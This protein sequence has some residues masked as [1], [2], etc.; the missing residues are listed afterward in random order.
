MTK[1][2]NTQEINWKQIIITAIIT[3]LMSLA[4]AIIVF[5]F[6]TEKTELI[7][8]EFPI[9][10]FQSNETELSILNY[11][12]KNIGQ[13]KANNVKI[14]IKLPESS[15]IKEPNI[16]LNNSLA[17]YKILKQEKNLIIYEIN[18]LYQYDNLNLSLLVENL[19]VRQ[20]IKIEIR[21]EDS[22]GTLNNNNDNSISPIVIYTTL[23][24]LIIFI[25]LLIVLVL[26][27]N[28]AAKAF[29]FFRKKLNEESEIE[30]RKIRD[31]LTQGVDYCDMGMSKESMR[32]LKKGKYLHPESSSIHANLAR[33]YARNSQMDKAIIEY[34]I[35]EKLI[36]ND[37]DKLIFNYTKAHYF[38]LI[39]DKDNMIIHLKEAK[40]L[41]KDRVLEKIMLDD[42]FDAYKSDNEFLLLIE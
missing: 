40:K 13:K 21:G 30:D 33:A 31:I 36:K 29:R 35:A 3:G 28:K 18:T 32:V 10:T 11:T 4:V 19:K 15:Y 20:G 34:K 42:E 38:A 17:E 37:T 14:Y 23:V 25:I 22:I 39:N 7:Y 1:N 5:F 8:E 27:A 16:E 41:D 2:K 9:S 26:I 24:L 6:T 12:V